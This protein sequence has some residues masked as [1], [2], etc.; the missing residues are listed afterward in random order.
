M[1]PTRARK[2][3]VT[4]LALSLVLLAVTLVFPHIK[5][6]QSFSQTVPQSQGFI[7][8][9]LHGYGVPA[10]SAGSTFTVALTGFVPGHLEYSLSPTA[11]N[12]VLAALSYGKPYTSNYSFEAVVPGGNSLE[13]SIIAYNGTGYALTYSGVWSPF[14]FLATYTFPAVFLV[15][16]SFVAAYYFGTRIPRQ[17]NEEAVVRELEETVGPRGRGR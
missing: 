9:Q 17:L 15:M 7:G 2:V 8:Y 14:D 13:L 6:P 4:I 3:S 1:K 5:T 11:G 12:T 10:V 16:A